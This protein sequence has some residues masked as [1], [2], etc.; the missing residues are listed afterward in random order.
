M[1]SLVQSTWQYILA[2][3]TGKSYN[4]VAVKR[5]NLSH[6]VHEYT[7]KFDASLNHS[8][9]EKKDADKVR[10]RKSKAQEMTNAYYDI[11]TDFYEYGWG[12]S[13][14]FA[15]RYP[16]EA[17]KQSLAR[18]EH[19]LALR[20]GLAAGDKCVDIGCGVGGPLR[21][22]ARFSQAHVTGLNNNEYQ[23]SRA[24]QLNAQ[25]DLLS[26]TD[27]VKADFMNLPFEADSFDKAYA[28]E[29]TCHAPDRTGCFKQIYKV[30]KDGGIFAGY[31]WTMTDA[32]DKN[33]AQHNVWKHGIEIGNSLPTLTHYT[34]IIQHLEA[35]GFEVIDHFDLALVPTNGSVPW[36]SSF[37]GGLT[38]AQFPHTQIGRMCTNTMCAV[39]ERVGLAP[40]GTTAT[41]R[42][43]G[44]TGTALAESGRAG[45]FTPM[46]MFI[47]RKPFK[48]E[49][50]S[51]AEG[52]KTR[53]SAVKKGTKAR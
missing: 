14:H 12:Q 29:A 17:F 37:L 20:L 36:Y 34:D 30:L 24:K 52:G 35:A 6:R 1:T 32:Y 53:Q 26:L 51:G 39:M 40:A 27:V 50:A 5:E 2:T 7:S 38:L 31:E 45:I 41:A 22:I 28:I 19:Y 33:N 9:D 44:E 46:Y 49:V 13:F 10:E 18:H 23:V 48:D 25:A 8:W 15:S 11:A 43:L 47:A 3:A 4:D 16:G 42:L 21:E